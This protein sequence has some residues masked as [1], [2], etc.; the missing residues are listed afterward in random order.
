VQA[1]RS[2]LERAGSVGDKGAIGKL[3]RQAA[4]TALGRG[5]LIDQ[6]PG[7]FERGAGRPAGRTRRRHGILGDLGLAAQDEH[8]PVEHA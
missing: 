6:R 3:Q 8:R 7:A 1:A 5:F 2:A 4:A